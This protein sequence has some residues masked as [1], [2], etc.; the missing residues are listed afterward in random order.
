MENLGAW[1]VRLTEEEF[2]SIENALEAVTIYGYRGHLESEQA[3]FVNN[4][5]DKE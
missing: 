4:W 1:N 3:S 2:E 5:K